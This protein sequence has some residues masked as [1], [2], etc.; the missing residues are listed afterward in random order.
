MRDKPGQLQRVNFG[1]RTIKM[2]I[3]RSA[4]VRRIRP[5][6]SIGCRNQVPHVPNNLELIL[7]VSAG[8]TGRVSN[9]FARISFQGS[10]F[11]NL[12]ARISLQ[13]FFCNKSGNPDC[14]R[15]QLHRL[16]LFADQPLR[17]I[18][19]LDLAPKCCSSNAQL[20]RCL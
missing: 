7:S 3:R 8:L 17:Q 12:F 2:V 16:R 6:C 11:K 9:S 10:L 20:C 4:G 19:F 5:E 15:P 1:N 14:L 13:E 18:I